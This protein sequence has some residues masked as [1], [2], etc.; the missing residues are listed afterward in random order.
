MEGLSRKGSRGT[1]RC[2]SVSWGWHGEFCFGAA[3]VASLGGVCSGW[4]GLER[5]GS[6]GGLRKVQSRKV[7]VRQSRLCWS[8]SGKMRS[9]QLSQGSYG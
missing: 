6:Q 9:G 7:R 4:Y 2:G 3:V 8:S 5:F 1:A